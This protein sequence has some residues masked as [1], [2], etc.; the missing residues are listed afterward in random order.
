MASLKF[1][2][3]K[4]D[5][6]ILTAFV[7]ALITLLTRLIYTEHYFVDADTVGFALGSV[8]YSLEF[9]RP[10]LPGYFLHVEIIAFLRKIFGNV[11]TVMLLLSVFY[12]SLGAF[13]TYLLLRKWLNKIT[14]VI[15]SFLVITNPMVWYYGSVTDSYTF[16]WFFSVFIV[17]LMLDKK[18]VLFIPLLIALGA[19][20]RQSTG[21]FLAVIFYLFFF[22]EKLYKNF[23]FS[24]LLISHIIAAAAGLTWLIPMVNS[25]DGIEN[26]LK[27]Y[28]ANSPLPRISIFQNF[29]QMSSYLVF[30]IVPYAAAA[31]EILFQW[32]SLK[33]IHLQIDYKMLKLILIWLIPPLLFFI[34]IVYSKGYF[35][36]IIVPF[37]IILGIFLKDGLISPAPLIISVFINVLIFFYFPYNTPSIESMLNPMIRTIKNYEVWYE[38]TT[39]SYLMAKSRIEYND[40]SMEEISFL[41]NQYSGSK[42]RGDISYFFLDPTSS[43]FA[44]GLQYEFPKLK[45]ITMNQ[46]SMGKYVLY[47]NLDITEKRGLQDVLKNCVIISRSDF[48][49]EYLFKYSGSSFSSSKYELMIPDEKFIKKIF[50]QYNFLFLR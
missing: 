3:A 2:I 24:R 13:F 18:Y 27:L 9:T 15:I 22:W 43:Y 12:S 19:G 39:S 28:S 33:R 4:P 35:L 34:F 16:D 11:H 46:L 49:S 17:Y 5:S 26:Y 37:Y 31:V 40:V 36:L 32:K 21:F 44:R 41:I 30:V 50:D 47:E 6:E 8:S 14:S 1:K 23:K 45:L 25:A 20:I 10:H 38:R 7:L 48:Y 42:G 29:Y